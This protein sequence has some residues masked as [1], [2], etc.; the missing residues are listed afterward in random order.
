MPAKRSR[1]SFEAVDCLQ[2]LRCASLS[3][4]DVEEYEEERVRLRR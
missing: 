1:K 2:V 3:E 4:D